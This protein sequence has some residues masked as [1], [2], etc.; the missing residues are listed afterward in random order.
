VEDLVSD[1]DKT[2]KRR[3]FISKILM[4]FGLLAGY[5]TAGV[6]GL[7]FLLPRK[8]EIKYRRL[9][10]AGMEDIPQ[11][12]SKTFYDLQGREMVLIN[13]ADGLK[14]LS[15]SCTHLGCKAYYE[16]GNNRFFCPCHDGVFD[17][18]GNVVSG[19][20]PRP[21]NSC[22]VEVDE[23]ENIFVLVRES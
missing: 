1:H 15:T 19:P 14:A 13:T 20:P 7:Q 9:L 3:T 5:G 4:F 16:P 23:N 12:S 6:Y 21:L 10:V 8:K 18:S 11:N 22:E 17:L 2:D